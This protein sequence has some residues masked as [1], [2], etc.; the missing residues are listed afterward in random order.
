M[1][2][3]VVRAEGMEGGARSL[4]DERTREAGSEGGTCTV[5]ARSVRDLG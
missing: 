1:R 5:A 2:S 4:V 3:T